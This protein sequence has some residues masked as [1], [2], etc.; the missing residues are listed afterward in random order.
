M[1]DEEKMAKIRELNKER[2]ELALEC[3]EA[4]EAYLRCAKEMNEMQLA[5]RKDDISYKDITDKECEVKILKIERD[6]IAC[7]EA[8]LRNEVLILE[9]DWRLGALHF[10]DRRNKVVPM[11]ERGEKRSESILELCQEE[12]VVLKQIAESL[13]K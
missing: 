3:I 4:E 6:L 11:W 13:Q 2:Y 9:S 7:K 5:K 12:I 1:N 10:D 8:R